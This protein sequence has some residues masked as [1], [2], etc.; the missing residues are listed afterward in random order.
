MQPRDS[1]LQFIGRM[2]RAVDDLEALDAFR[3]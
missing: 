1:S 3:A 2:A